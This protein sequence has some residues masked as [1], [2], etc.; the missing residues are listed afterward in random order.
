MLPNP[1]LTVCTFAFHLA[2]FV[3]VIS[4]RAFFMFDTFGDA[5]KYNVNSKIQYRSLN[6]WYDYIK[7]CFPLNLLDLKENT[8]IESK[9][10]H[11]PSAKLNY[12]VTVLFTNL[13]APEK[14]NDFAPM[15]PFFVISNRSNYIL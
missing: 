9:P 5:S 1:N 6:P 8:S 15:L 14:F 13:F 2:H 4:Q 3:S 7:S 11:L 10:L 12:H